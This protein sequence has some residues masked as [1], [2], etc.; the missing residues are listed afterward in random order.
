MQK[1]LICTKVCVELRKTAPEAHEMLKTSFGDITM[2]RTWIFSGFLDSNVEKTAKDRERGGRS[3]IV[4]GDEEFQTVRKIVKE[5]QRKHHF[6]NHRQVWPLV[7]NMSVDSKGG[8]IDVH[9]S[10]L[11]LCLA[12]PPTSK[13]QQKF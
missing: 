12:S 3:S 9:G 7:W 5:E 13:K 8:F 10:P 6:G 4:S 2:G 11:T 1:E